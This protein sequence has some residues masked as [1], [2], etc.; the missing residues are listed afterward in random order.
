VF[1]FFL[2]FPRVFLLFFPPAKKGALFSHPFFSLF[3]FFFFLHLLHKRDLYF[4]SPLFFFLSLFPLSVFKTRRWCC[5]IV[6]SSPFFFFFL[7]RNRSGKNLRGDLFCFSSFLLGLDFKLSTFCVV[8]FSFLASPP[9][10]PSRRLGP[11]V[12]VLFPFFSLVFF[13]S[14]SEADGFKGVPSIF[15]FF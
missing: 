10:S 9:P 3:F 6:P 7:F 1:P 4:F 11:G 14:P 5:R 15:F 13:F 2:P 8:S 12:L